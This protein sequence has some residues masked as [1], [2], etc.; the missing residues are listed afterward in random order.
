MDQISLIMFTFTL[1]MGF[2]FSLL[3]LYELK[4]AISEKEAP[5]IGLIFCLLSTIIW[6]IV[7]YLWPA[8]ATSDMFVSLGLL[9]LGLGWV[10]L[11]ITF[12]CVFYIL[13]FSVSKQGGALEIREEESTS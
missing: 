3:G 4:G 2:I 5:A 11:I 12:A 9:W 10:F 1:A 8:V 13:K 6:F 7:S